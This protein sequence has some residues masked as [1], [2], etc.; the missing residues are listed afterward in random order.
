MCLWNYIYKK[1]FTEFISCFHL[2]ATINVWIWSYSKVIVYVSVLDVL[3]SFFF[4]VQAEWPSQVIGNNTIIVLLPFLFFVRHTKLN[5]K[6]LEW[7]YVC[8]S[9][10][11]KKDIFFYRWL[12]RVM[13]IEDKKH[14]KQ[15]LP[16]PEVDNIILQF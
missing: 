14:C 16:N 7:F 4:S 10:T 1:K 15:C 2:E 3:Y 11:F 9:K 5:F 13:K 8:R 6:L 12:Y